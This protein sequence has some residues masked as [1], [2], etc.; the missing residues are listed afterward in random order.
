MNFVHPLV[1]SKNHKSLYNLILFYWIF[2]FRLFFLA[3]FVP[4]HNSFHLFFR[5]LF[6]STV[7]AFN[8][9]NVESNRVSRIFL[10]TQCSHQINHYGICFEQLSAYKV[11]CESDLHEPLTMSLIIA[12]RYLLRSFGSFIDTITIMLLLFNKNYL[13]DWLCW[14]LRAIFYSSIVLVVHVLT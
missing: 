9:H 3:F 1:V 4:F 11:W 6:F 10:V 7:I 14:I 2:S 8:Y 12:P 5:V 13:F